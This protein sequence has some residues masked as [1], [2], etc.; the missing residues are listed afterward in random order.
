LIEPPAE[1]AETIA[2][3]RER[4][5]LRPRERVLVAAGG[6]A[7]STGLMAFVAL[8]REALAL[9]RVS[10]VTVDDGS[11]E[12]SERCADAARSARSLGLEIHVVEADRE[13]VIAR[14]QR[15]RRAL[16]YD[17]LA[18]GDTVEDGA[19]RALRELMGDRAVR[20]LAARRADGVCRPLLSTPI[21]TADLFTKLAGLEPPSAPDL[22]AAQGRS[23]LDRAVREGILPRVRAFWPGADR[24]LAELPRRMRAQRLR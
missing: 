3:V 16:G 9:R 21:R 5:V 7:A 23:A 1:L 24:A 17:A 19:A 10:V 6:G 13:A 18:L 2:F 8:A 22:V 12:G 15:L 14:C 20:G 11:D 4:R